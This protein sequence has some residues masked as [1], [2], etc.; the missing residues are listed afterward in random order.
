MV[1]VLDDLENEDHSSGLFMGAKIG[2]DGFAQNVRMRGPSI[3]NFKDPP[4]ILY[5]ALLV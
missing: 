5:S 4:Y 3:E 2:R 1:V